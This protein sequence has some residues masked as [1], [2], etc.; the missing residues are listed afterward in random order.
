MLEGKFACRSTTSTNF[1]ALGTYGEKVTITATDNEGEYTIKWAD[2]YNYWLGY[3]TYIKIGSA[4]YNYVNFLIAESSRGYSIQRSPRNTNYYKADE[5]IGFNGSNGDRL[6]PA[7]AEGSI[8]WQL[9]TVDDAEYYFAKHKLYTYLEVADQYNFYITQYDLVYNNNASTTAELDFAQAMLKDALD[10]SQNLVSP[11]WTEHPILLQ[12]NSDNKWKLS[13]NNKKLTWTVSRGNTEATS[14]LVGTVNVDA[15]A[16]LCYSYTS[17]NKKGT[18]RVYL[19]GELIQI[20]KPN[21]S[22]QI[23]KRY[24]IELTAGKHDITW[25]CLYNNATP[26]PGYYDLFYLSEIGVK[27]TPTI[28]PAATTVEGQL[29]TEVLKLTE[30]VANVKKIVIN[31]VIG[32]DDWT[33]I[34]MM[35]NAFSIDMSG[36]TAT[37]PMP[38]NMFNNYNNDNKWQFLHNVKLPQ[39]LTAIGKYAF[40]NSD[41]ENEIT[42]PES[43]TSIGEYAFNSSK[44]K[45]AYMPDGVTSIGKSAF[46]YCYYMENA[47]WP[48]TAGIIPEYCFY[49]NYNLRSF[50]IPEGITEI[51][52]R[53]FNDCEQFNVRFPSS[54]SQINEWAFENTG[55]KTSSLPVR[56][57]SFRP[58]SSVPHS[59]LHRTMPRSNIW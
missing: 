39:G 1:V 57:S 18:M 21:Q 43:L 28:T 32:A 37:A 47:T 55:L 33:T 49:K 52:T 15:D 41:V 46:G 35:V 25:T 13:D 10:M 50:T 2:T 23:S 22:Y 24:Y 3:D 20:I 56:A 4:S 14:T 30:S 42:F 58:V 26:N 6:T 5:Y 44:I 9:M 48:A 19:D 59:S 34:G 36:A 17:P 11:S 16:T 29:G 40:N 12:N 38:D 27:N 8:H 45:A 54:I 51:G 53:A 31:G 7:L